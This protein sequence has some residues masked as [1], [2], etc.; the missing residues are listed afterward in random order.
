MGHVSSIEQGLCLPK[1]LK[2]E[3]CLRH[4]TTF[5]LEQHGQNARCVA[6]RPGYNC[7]R[8]RLV[9]LREQTLCHGFRGGFRACRAAIC[10]SVRQNGPHFVQKSVC[11][12]R[13]TP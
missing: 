6:I 10:H 11:W 2:K 12:P 9:A 13:G 8:A 3:G 4:Y 5:W 1:Y 7:R